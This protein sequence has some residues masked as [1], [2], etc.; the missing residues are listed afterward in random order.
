[1]NAIVIKNLENEQINVFVEDFEVLDAYTQ[2][3]VNSLKEMK[4][5]IDFC[6]DNTIVRPKGKNYIILIPNNKQTFG[7][8]IYEDNV[9]QDLQAFET[10]KKE[11]NTT[12]IGGILNFQFFFKCQDSNQIAKCR[13][14]MVNDGNIVCR[15]IIRRK[16]KD[17][18]EDILYANDIQELTK[19]I[20]DCVNC[21]YKENYIEKVLVIRND[22][23]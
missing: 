20:I 23:I 6:N 8:E 7:Y 13:V 22:F 17:V 2:I 9:T 5:I 21:F 1:M 14:Y 16:E 10:V 3:E 15:L 12:T 18:E 11:L 4:K 19:K